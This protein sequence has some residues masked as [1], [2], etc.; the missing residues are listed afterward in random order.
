M[1]KRTLVALAAGTAPWG[2][3]AAAAVLVKIGGGAA[4]ESVSKE[5]ATP[6]G[7]TIS[8]GPLPPCLPEVDRPTQRSAP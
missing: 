4:A 3:L 2:A 6:L 7:L 5:R 8:V 1:L